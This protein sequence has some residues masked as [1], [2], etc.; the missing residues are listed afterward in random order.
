MA[1]LWS[2]PVIPSNELLKSFFTNLADGQPMSTSLR[3]AQ[4]DMIAKLR[5]TAEVAHPA[6]WAAFTMTGECH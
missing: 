6:Y 4:L 5:K 2:I 1:S 3:N